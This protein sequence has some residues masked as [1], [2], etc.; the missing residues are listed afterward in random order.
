MVYWPHNKTKLVLCGNTGGGMETAGAASHTRLDVGGDAIHHSRA[1]RPF[2]PPPVPAHADDLAR[3]PTRARGQGDRAAQEPA[4]DDG[5]PA[6]H[7][8]AFPSTVLSAFTSRPFSWGVPTVT[9]SA[10]SMPNGVI[11]RPITPSFRSR[12]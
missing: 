4:A 1:Q 5:Q 3:H 12:W 7:A 6:D 8:G 9:R 2:Q 11:G 10:D